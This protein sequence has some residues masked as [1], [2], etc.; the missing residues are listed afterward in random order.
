M[1]LKEILNEANACI[2]VCNYNQ[3][4]A[5]C[6]TD[7]QWTFVGETSLTGIDEVMDYMKEAYIEPPRFKIDL[8][9]EEGNYLTAVG[10]I[11]IVNTDSL[12][13]SYE[14]CDVWRFEN[15]KLAGLKGFIA[16]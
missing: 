11:S 15:G 13:I 3:F 10:T 9:I 7:T 8:M 6:T 16:N 4:L 1:N 2:A 14:Y 12:L 5:Y